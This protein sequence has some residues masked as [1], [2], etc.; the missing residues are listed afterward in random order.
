MAIENISE[1]EQSLGIEAGKLTEM[2]TSEEKHTVDL[3]GYVIKSKGD[4]EAFIGNIKKESGAAAVE[5]A[6]KT[7]RKDKG[8]EFEGKTMANL[9]KFYGE[10]V[11]AD[12]N[13]EPNKKYDTLKTDYDIRGE[14]ITEWEGKYSKLEGDWNNEK[15]GRDINNTLLKAI[16]DN[17]SIPKEDILAIL[18]SKHQFKNGEDGF[19]IIGAD[20]QPLKNETNRNLVTPGEFMESFIKP[21]LKQVEGGGGDDD[22]GDDRKPKA[23]SY[24]AFEKEMEKAG[25]TGAKLTMEMQKRIKDGTLKV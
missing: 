14:K 18:K 2:V 10:K 3:S 15:N 17:V 5:I 16:P 20:G 24:D 23:G 4:H 21:Y 1:I 13:I 9:L 19:E 8:L 12:A 6:V 22:D 11:V 25:I 7:A